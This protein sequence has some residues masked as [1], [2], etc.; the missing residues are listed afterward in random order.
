MTIGRSIPEIAE[1]A[2][3]HLYTEYECT[4]EDIV[5]YMYYYIIKVTIVMSDKIELIYLLSLSWPN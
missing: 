3:L 5:I 2:R 4:A 1:W